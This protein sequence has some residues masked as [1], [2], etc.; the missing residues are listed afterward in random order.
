MMEELLRLSRFV[1]FVDYGEFVEV[2]HGARAASH[3]MDRV[4]Y[5]R[6]RRFAGF[7]QREAELDAW[8]DAGVLVAPF[9]D[10]LASHGPVA[11]SEAELAANYQRWYWRH[12]V[13][14]EREY[15]WLGEVV[16]KMPSD[17]FY[18]QELLA[19]QPKRRVL[20]LGRGRGGGL[21]Y[22]ASALHLLGGGVLASIDV[23]DGPLAM[24]VSRWVDVEL[25]VLV[26]DAFGS[27]SVQRVR[28]VAEGFELL[29]IDLGGDPQRNL[30]ALGIWAEMVADGGRVVVEDL[31]GEDDGEALRE[32]D[33]F[34]LARREFGLCERGA[35]HPLLKGI[36]LRRNGGAHAR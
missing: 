1:V 23:D 21:W 14:T 35:R 25:H 24:D 26:G 16:V 31:W 2:Q 5:E 32:L 6:L 22:L 13:E 20:E 17:L 12:E 15:R 4:L 11:G 9:A 3:R 34:L 19:E 30:T 18:L 10:T 36:G 28:A 33:T 7:R 27:E 8:V 29:V